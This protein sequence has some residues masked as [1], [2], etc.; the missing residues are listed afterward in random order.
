MPGGDSVKRAETEGECL[1]FK[2]CFNQDMYFNTAVP[3][4]QCQ[5]P[6]I[7]DADQ[8]KWKNVLEWDGGEWYPSKMSSNGIKW[9]ERKLVPKNKWAKVIAWN[10]LDNLVQEAGYALAAEA[11][12]TEFNCHMEPLYDI[13]EQVAC[14]C[15]ADRASDKCL[16]VV[17]KVI[18]ST[19]ASQTVF[20]NDNEKTIKTAVGSVTI[21]AAVI[22]GSVKKGKDNV[23]VDVQA[24]PAWSLRIF[25]SQRRVAGA[26]TSCS[27]FEII[28][29]QGQ[30]VGQLMGN[31]L[32]I[33]GLK[34]GS[35]NVCIPIDKDIPKCTFKYIVTDFALGDNAGQPGM[36]LGREIL[37]SLLATEFLHTISI[38]LIFEN[39]L[40]ETST[41]TDKTEQI[42]GLV[43][44]VSTSGLLV[45]SHMHESC[46]V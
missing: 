32:T 16:R 17:G 37:K 24:T 11:F 14:A 23:Q 5:N 10:V 9:T 3:E 20:L 46:P 45:M 38:A 28:K 7:C 15:S 33:Q 19:V 25:E 35:A 31:G 41:T 8:F 36:L 30:V 34:S 18:T 4:A 12:K 6:D 29:S 1:R 43:P 44:L 39:F 21:T 27:D 22:A 13:L 2:G 42:C 40:P 26:G